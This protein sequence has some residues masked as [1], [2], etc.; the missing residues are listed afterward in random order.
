MP[1]EVG[2]SGRGEVIG[3]RSNK[4]SPERNFDARRKRFHKKF[5]VLD[6]GCEGH[7]KIWTEVCVPSII[8]TEVNPIISR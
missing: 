7:E 3:G 5:T 8:R 1:L 2:G 6:L 4:R